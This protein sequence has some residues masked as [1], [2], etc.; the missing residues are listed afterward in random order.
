MTAM[1]IGFVATGIGVVIIVLTDCFD[2]GHSR[3]V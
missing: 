3:D 1:R 2:Q